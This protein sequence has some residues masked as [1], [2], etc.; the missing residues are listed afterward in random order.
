MCFVAEIVHHSSESVGM[1]F[2][3]PINE[4]GAGHCAS[5]VGILAGHF[6]KIGRAVNDGGYR[7]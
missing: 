4:V 2:D 3:V 5:E 7:K 6:G 1:S